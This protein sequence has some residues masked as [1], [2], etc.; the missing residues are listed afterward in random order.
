M[1]VEPENRVKFLEWIT[2]TG[3]KGGRA[4][5]IHHAGTAL[6]EA[7]LRVPFLSSTMTWATNGGMPVGHMG[8]FYGPEGSGKS[9]NNWGLSY[10]A[11]NYPEVMTEILEREIRFWQNQG[12]KFKATAIKGRLKRILERFPDGMSVCL[13]DTEQRAQ[14]EFGARLGVDMNKDR[15]LMIEENVIEEVI[16][17][18][19]EAL[20]SY[21]IM[22]VDSASNAQ[23]YAE[24]NLD[25]GDYEQGTASQAWKRLRQTRRKLDREMN[26]IIFVDQMRMQLGQKSYTGPKAKP[27]QNRFLKHNTSLAI[28][29]DEGRRLYLNNDLRLTDDRDKA[30]K[31]FTQLASSWPEIAGLEMRAQ[32]AKNST[33]KPFRN[34]VMRMKFD[35]ANAASGELVQEAGFDQPY[36]ALVLAEHFRLV[37]S[38]STGWFYVLDDE[39]DRVQIQNGKAKPTDY[40]FRGEWRA[41]QGLWDDEEE[42]ERIL[43]RTRI[44]T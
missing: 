25:P 42:R 30:N 4:Q 16:R 35:M 36:E 40:R 23:S 29:F 34:A 41:A 15:F 12:N 8:R 19:T 32:V 31:E 28:E 10:C 38:G 11:Q 27:P 37:E 14:M 3:K 44:A 6:A 21:H 39:G 43:T 22:I 33:G 1:P 26:T 5:A 2:D 20:G 18:M 17:Q 24:A 7:P 9:L 13:W